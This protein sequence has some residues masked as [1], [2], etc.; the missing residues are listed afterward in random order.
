[1]KFVV[2]ICLLF[3]LIG[4]ALGLK[5]PICGEPHSGDGQGAIR[6]AAYMPKWTYN[7]AANECISFIY[8]GCGGN[9]NRFGSQAECEEKC[10]E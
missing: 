5:D 3:A 9:A 8:G 4:V 1:M 10:K 6:C 2:A 7:S